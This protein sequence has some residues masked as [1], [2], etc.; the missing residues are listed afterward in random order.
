MIA[1]YFF[2]N[3]VNEDRRSLKLYSLKTLD[4]RQPQ[5]PC[6]TYMFTGSLGR[7]TDTFLLKMFTGTFEVHGHF[8]LK[9]FTGILEIHGHFFD[10][11]RALLRFTGIFFFYIHGHMQNIHGHFCE[12][13]HGHF[14]EVHGEKK[15][16]CAFLTLKF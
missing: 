8:F 15:E 10:G 16:H 7:F 5:S 6:R 11:S 3:T 9:V 2:Q 1:A 14:F 12:N 13:V 4:A